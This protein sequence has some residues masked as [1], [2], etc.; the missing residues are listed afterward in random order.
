VLAVADIVAQCTQLE[1]ISG[2]KETKER[3]Q[4]QS[5][6]KKN[7]SVKNRKRSSNL[8]NMPLPK[9]WTKGIHSIE[10]NTTKRVAVYSAPTSSS[11]FFLLW[12]HI[13]KNKRKTHAQTKKKKNNINN[14]KNNKRTSEQNHKYISRH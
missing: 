5:R 3:K 13:P 11:H 4:K 10:G 2:T 7:N 8:N 6:K 14:F 12:M 9:F 1:K